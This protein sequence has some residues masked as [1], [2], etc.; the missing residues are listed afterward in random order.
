[1]NLIE[2]VPTIEELITLA[3][4]PPPPFPPLLPLPDPQPYRQAV[5]VEGYYRPGDGGGGLFH[6]DPYSMATPDLGINFLSSSMNDPKLPGRWRRQYSGHINVMYFGVTKYPDYQPPIGSYSNTARLQ[7]A[8]DYSFST[9]A[10]PQHSTA[11]D[12]L[13]IYFPAGSYWIDK[14]VVLYEQTH[15][16]G[17]DGT[18]L[19]I[20]NQV[21]YMFVIKRSPTNDGDVNRLYVEN[22]IMN[23]GAKRENQPPLF[24]GGFLFEAIVTDPKNPKSAGGLWSAVI[25][26]IKIVN[27]NGHGI[28]MRGGNSESEPHIGRKANQYINVD[29]V[30]IER[31]NEEKNCI[32]MT[33]Q[34][35]NVSFMNCV[36]SIPYYVDKQ[37]PDLGTNIHIDSLNPGPQPDM[38]AQ[39]RFIN[40]ATGGGPGKAVMH[41][42]YMRN[43]E[44]ITLE[45]CWIE[46]T[47]VAINI[48]DS[49]AINIL[50][51][52]FANAAGKGTHDGD[53]IR[54][55]NSFVNV[56]RNFILTSFPETESARPARF[57]RGLDD[58]NVINARN[59]SFSHIL[60]SNTYGITQYADIELVDTYY[61]P[62]PNPYAQVPGIQTDG[63]KIELIRTKPNNM[64]DI[65]RINSKI[66]AGEMLFL[67]AEDGDFTIHAMDPVNELTG[68]NIYLGGS[69]SLT[70][71]HGTCITLMKLDGVNHQEYCQYQVMSK[72]P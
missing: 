61:L 25:K 20:Q 31:M 16:K 17:D 6:Y 60:L 29:N 45:N 70:V 11:P 3:L 55:S 43:A 7:N 50:N 40:C 9:S 52:R 68:H 46:D 23:L 10:L 49:K 27:M 58:N 64:K 38:N 53:C 18:E 32:R 39:I 48:V 57:I 47:E 67:R 51:T 71:K 63:K 14:T 4:A 72:F 24:V 54:T 1:M 66:A 69:S 44:N 34:Q 59:N 5:Y 56:E 37:P 30:W 22:F 28:E 62:T 36:F 21:N 65:H 15:I 13:T 35:V 42:F 19:N 33:G 2:V 8:I 12:D 41:A 26:D